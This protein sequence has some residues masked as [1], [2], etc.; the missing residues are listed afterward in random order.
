MA[1]GTRQF[2]TNGNGDWLKRGTAREDG[3]IKDDAPQFDHR[4]PLEIP[5]SITV[6]VQKVQEK[7]SGATIWIHRQA[8]GPGNLEPD[9]TAER[10]EMFEVNQGL[11]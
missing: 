4:L 11:A 1:G 2:N 9:Q 10:M 3:V 5:N 7:N 6:S 8:V